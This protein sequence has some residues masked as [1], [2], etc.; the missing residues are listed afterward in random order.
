ML[1]RVRGNTAGIK[2]YVEKGHKK[3]RDMERDEMD[4]RVILAGDLQLTHD[5]I[6]SI[7]TDAERYLHITLSFKEDYI[8]KEVLENIVADFE[9]FAF[10]AYRPDEY[11]FY[12]E[13]HLPKIKA[14]TNRKN[15]EYVERKPHIH[16]VIPTVNLMSGQRLDPFGLVDNQQRYLNAIQEHI[17]HKYGLAS[18]ADNRRVQFT[19]ASE[20]ISRYKGDVFE[21]SNTDTKAKILDA[22][23]TRG[24]N[25]YDDFKTVLA[26]FGETRTRNAGRAGEYENVKP[27]GAAKGINLKEYVFSREFIE[28]PTDRKQQAITAKA[29]PQYDTAG[30]PKATPA[31]LVALLQE[32]ESVRAK[33][34]KYLN[35]AFRAR[36]REMTADDQRKILAERESNFYQRYDTE[37]RNDGSSR[38]DNSVGRTDGGRR[39]GNS[40]THQLDREAGRE[41]REGRQAQ[42]ERFEPTAEWNTEHDLDADRRRPPAQ[43]ID[44]V[45]GLQSIGLDGQPVRGEVLLPDNARHQLGDDGP[46]TVDSLRWD[47]TG[48]GTGSGGRAVTSHWRYELAAEY[49]RYARSEAAE[50]QAIEAASAAKLSGSYDYLK[51]GGRMPASFDGQTRPTSLHRTRKLSAT[52]SLHPQSPDRLAARARRSQMTRAHGERIAS[53]Y[54]HAKRGGRMPASFD[55][56][57]QPTSPPGRLADRARR[58]QMTHAQGERVARE[59]DT[60]KGGSRLR[61]RRPIDRP[62][63]LHDVGADPEQR[64]GVSPPASGQRPR[65]ARNT[66]TGRE[67]D[68]LL[69]QLERD[70]HERREQRAAG[71]RT[72]FQE[73]KQ[74]LDASRLLA[75]LAHSHGVVSEKYTITRAR[76]GSDRIK[77]GNRNLNVSDFLTKEM[78]L[79]WSEAARIM[80]DTY[81]EQVGN[82]PE[83]LARQTPQQLFWREYQDYRHEQLTDFRN[84]W[85]AQGAS[86]RQRRAAIRDVYTRQRSQIQGNPALT[87]AEK[88]SAISIARV[89]RIGKDA[90]LREV[91]A[92]ERAELKKHTRYRIDDHYREFLATRAQAGDERALQE[93]RRVQRAGRPEPEDEPRVSPVRQEPNAIIYRG[94][95]VTHEV[96]LNGD[97]TYKQ[98]GR[99]VLDDE[100]RSLRLW[101]ADDAA[102]ELA[103]RLA[104]HKYGPVL[105]VSGPEE[106]QLAAARVAAQANLKVEFSDPALNKAMRE[107]RAAIDAQ[108]QEAKDRERAREQAI[109]QMAREIMNPKPD[110]KAPD[111]ERGD[112]PEVDPGVER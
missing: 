96:H 12:A 60:A 69:D 35:G 107:Q 100:G 28:L 95:I 50:Q 79:P 94:P 93:L 104:Q 10:A 66:A 97:V 109:R 21:G 48:R 39:R 16:V 103:L 32:W 92:N 14:Y 55:G 98:D 63:R 68:T 20:M 111:I 89:N 108:Q 6:E 87:P 99:A 19:D 101:E 84:S 71:P 38:T 54:D 106:F 53:E 37:A 5:I 83:Y 81:R 75:S 86:E 26:E 4:E 72:E 102:V 46:Q 91:I 36:Y 40:R 70:L 13:T 7:D 65:R 64:E 61:G 85:L 112:G 2:E 11:V 88:K 82:D 25:N 17:N 52:P 73:I 24:V 41:G 22:V 8:D 76:D 1:I 62:R 44:R 33:E 42:P 74:E 3:G 59:Y 31:P 77:A 57:T 90:E 29:T 49:D 105:E 9:R 80:R 110:D 43:S 67:A 58:S 51:G 30:N 15:G 27:A 56:Q 23:L 47:R 78:N 34:V 45:R 18:P